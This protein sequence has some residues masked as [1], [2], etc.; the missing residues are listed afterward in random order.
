MAL[1]KYY[2]LVS[3]LLFTLFSCS[4]SGDDIVEKGEDETEEP[5][6]KALGDVTKQVTL[7]GNPLSQKY[8][9]NT[10]KVYA[11]NIWD[12]HAFNNK[13]YFGGGNSSNSGPAV[14]AGP[15]DLWVYDIASK[16]FNKEYTVNEEQIHRIR[17]FDGQLYIPGHDSRESWSFGNFYRLEKGEWKKYR[18]IPNGIHVYDIYK[19]GNKLI[20]ATGTQAPSTSIQVSHDDGQTWHNAEYVNDEGSTN[21]HSNRMYTIFPFC[22]KLYVPNRPYPMTYTG[23]GNTFREIINNTEAVALYANIDIRV[24]RMERPVVFGE[25]TVYILGSTDNDHQYLPVALMYANKPEN[26][27]RHELPENTLPRDIMVKDNYLIVLLSAQQKDGRYYN[28]V[29]VTSDLSA[30]SVQWTELFG[31]TS[32]TFARSFEYLNGT[33]YFG[34]G[35]ETD[36]LAQA[37]GNILAFDYDL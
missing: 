4:D 2:L 31:F 17:E 6:L 22:G 9:D 1:H 18:T 32:E 20:A 5:T 28:T 3:L 13:I 29:I 23:E 33:F 30:E 15:A 27:V 11:R 16:S 7:L 12:M 21:Y 14:N 24:T 35:C 19:W 26:V 10:P 37:T 8:A 36:V 25:Y 34:L